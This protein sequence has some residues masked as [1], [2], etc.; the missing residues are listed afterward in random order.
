MNIHTAD[1][2]LDEFV[3]F[4]ATTEDKAQ[5]KQAAKQYGL[6]TSSYLRLVLIQQGVIRD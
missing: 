6:N 1:L 4:R 5:I 3:R 2:P